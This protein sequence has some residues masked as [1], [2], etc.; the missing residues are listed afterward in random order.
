LI[1]I[2]DGK[3]HFTPIPQAQTGFVL[4]GDVRDM[5]Y[6]NNKKLIVGINNQKVQV[7]NLGFK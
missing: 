3:G 2:G 6:L 7:F 5:V 4:R 1:L